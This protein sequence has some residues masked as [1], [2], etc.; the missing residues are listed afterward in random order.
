MSLFISLAQKFIEQSKFDTF[1][2]WCEDISKMLHFFRTY[3]LKRK[4]RT[5]CVLDNPQM[6]IDP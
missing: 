6:T 2:P 4:E 5:F 3:L 1:Y